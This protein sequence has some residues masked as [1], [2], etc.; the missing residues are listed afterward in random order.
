MS[1]PVQSSSATPNP[2]ERSSNRQ[3]RLKLI[4]RRFWPY[5][6]AAE[7]QAAELAQTLSENGHAI[8]LLTIR[9]DSDW[10]VQFR[11]EDCSVQRLRRPNHGPWGYYRYLKTIF[12]HISSDDIDGVILMGLG[13]ELVTVDKATAGRIPFEVV[14][15]EMDLGIQAELTSLSNRE[16]HALRNAAKIIVESK[17]SAER[18]A[19]TIDVDSSRIDVAGD[20]ICTQPATQTLLKKNVARRTLGDAHPMLV[21]PENQPLVICHSP[22]VGDQGMVDLV[23]A[24]KRVDKINPNARLWII[25]EGP[26]SREVWD[27]ISELGLRESII[28][29][30]QFD[31]LSDVFHA[32][33]IIVHPLRSRLHCGQLLRG[34]AFGV[35]P[36]L[37]IEL[38][39]RLEL[40]DSAHPF[41]FSRLS[42]PSLTQNLLA[43]V[44]SVDPLGEK[45]TNPNSPHIASRFAM[46]DRITAMVAPFVN[47]YSS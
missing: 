12:Q 17:W 11:Y 34:L 43:A 24:W 28:M 9:W 29:P 8:E 33:D 19:A 5:A 13:E 23:R 31:E 39:N 26:N 30:G 15:S 25:G 7:F 27:A 1:T 10:P 14:L 42:L 6:G 2:D 45:P 46:K 47:Q 32:A 20:G 36:L 3:L 22:M 21:I 4:S 35:R 18:L 16:L 40:P 37:P 38:A 44:E 41:L